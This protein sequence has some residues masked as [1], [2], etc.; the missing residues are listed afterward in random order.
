MRTEVA[1]FA[2]REVR[3]YVQINKMP[4]KRQACEV[5]LCC[6]SWDFNEVSTTWLFSFAGNAPTITGAIPAEGDKG[7]YEVTL[8]NPIRASY[9]SPEIAK[10]GEVV[11]ICPLLHC[12]T[13]MLLSVTIIT[14]KGM[15][16]CEAKSLELFV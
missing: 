11:A 3:V 2:S 5:H 16:T 9:R 10:R 14:R 4:A 13:T 7:S 6:D 1:F 15:V 8:K 12:E